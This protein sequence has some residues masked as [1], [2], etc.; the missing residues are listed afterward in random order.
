MKY[1]MCYLSKFDEMHCENDLEILE[2]VLISKMIMMFCLP[3]LHPVCY[4]NIEVKHMKLQKQ[5]ARILQ[6]FKSVEKGNDKI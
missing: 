5:N 6:M 4:Y 3:L 2:L 1:V